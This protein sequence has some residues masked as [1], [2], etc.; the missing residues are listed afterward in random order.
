MLPGTASSVPLSTAHR[1]PGSRS[2]LLP[3]NG[4]RPVAHRNIN[5]GAAQLAPSFYLDWL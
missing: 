3:C 1:T 2:S 5:T 4:K